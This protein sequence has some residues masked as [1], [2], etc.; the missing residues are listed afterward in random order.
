MQ[1]A[2]QYT[3]LNRTLILFPVNITSLRQQKDL[4]S[5][6]S[7]KLHF[8]EGFSTNILNLPVDEMEFLRKLSQLVENY[9]K[10]RK[11]EGEITSGLL[12]LYTSEI[13]CFRLRCWPHPAYSMDFVFYDVS[14]TNQ[15]SFGK[16]AISKSLR[17]DLMK[18]NKF[19]VTSFAEWNN[20][21]GVTFTHIICIPLP[22]GNKSNKEFIVLRR[23]ITNW[24][25]FTLNL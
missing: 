9:L 18:F 3:K 19:H 13:N 6:A 14:Q 8:P 17:I 25:V 1:Q 23:V 16:V 21:L 24:R 22:Y 12:C 20:S 15:R 2:I 7:F 5:I 11:A 10:R 4:G